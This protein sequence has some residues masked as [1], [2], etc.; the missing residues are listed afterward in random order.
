MKSLFI[1]ALY[2]LK[3]KGRL[4]RGIRLSDILFLTNDSKLISP[5][6]S[7]N[8]ERITGLSETETLRHANSVIYAITEHP[9]V[10]DLT[11]DEAKN[12]LNRKLS[13]L[14]FFLMSLWLVKDNSVNVELG[15]LEHPHGNP[16]ASSV[17][18][19][20][21]AMHFCDASGRVI[22]CDFTE[23]EVRKARDFYKLFEES[24]VYLGDRTSGYVVPTDFTRFDRVLYFAQAARGTKDLGLK[25]ANYV[26]CFECLFCTESAE[27]A[28]K[29]S[30]RVAFF[31]G[32]KSEERL[33][34]FKISKAAY[35]IRS[36]TVHGDPIKSHQ[37][38]NA[39][40]LAMKCDNMLREIIKRILSSSS[41]HET[42]IGPAKDLDEFFN[43]L[44]FRLDNAAVSQAKT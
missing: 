35:S 4:G 29:L 34:Y 21:R 13:L 12:F 37:I 32:N 20:F 40:K 8:F 9:S 42:F 27:L 43:G 41:L 10:A 1:A 14:Q 22:D 44:V 26:T 24:A 3:L 2:N 19:N 16:Y 28:H 38:D 30:E 25:I 31:L 33:E 7:A 15:F 11:S 18:S 5:L 6:L 36:K 23:K 17:T 39:P